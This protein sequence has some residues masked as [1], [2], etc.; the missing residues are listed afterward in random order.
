MKLPNAKLHAPAGIP[1]DYQ[2]HIKLML[3]LMVLAFQTDVTRIA[4]FMYANEGSNKSYA[5]IGVSE[6]HHDLSHHGKDQGKQEKITKIN[7]FHMNQF[8]YMLE[9]MR[10]IREGEGALLDH[11]MIVYGSGISDGD[12]HN[13]DDLPV[14]LAG[15]AN[16]AITSGR[17]VRYANQTP[18]NNLF[19]SMLEI[20]GASTSSLGDS[21][22][23]LDKLKA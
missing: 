10:S 12:R 4:T 15:K 17:H 19:L 2:E 22:G 23:K 8:A 9:K 21:T 3:D 13:H 11:S 20:M 5:E 7:I 16:G 18:L 1:G 14:L 6:G